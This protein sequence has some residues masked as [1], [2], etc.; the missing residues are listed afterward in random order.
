MQGLSNTLVSLV[1]VSKGLGN[2]VYSCLESVLLQAHRPTEVILIDNSGSPELRRQVGSKYPDVRVHVLG[3]DHSYCDSLN[4][5][6]AVSRGEFVLC[7]NDDVVLTA[8]FISEAL[9]GFT[10]DQ[11]IGMVSGKALRFD[12]Q[13][14]D[15]AGLSL[16]CFASARERGY[17]VRDKGQFET[18]GYIFG[19]CGAMA[20]YR[21]KMLDDIMIDSGF[22]DP[23][24]R[25]FYEDLDL[26]WRANNL[27]WKCFY[28]PKAIAYHLRGASVRDA[29]GIE[30]KH[31][32]L[33]LN[34]ELLAD[35]VKN[36]YL[37]IIK[38][39]S[40]WGFLLRLPCIFAY[41][42]I[43]WGHLLF[44]RPRVIGRVLSKTDLINRAFKKRSILKARKKALSR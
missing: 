13:T 33:Y 10:F 16:S 18:P 1:I 42:I 23:D 15:T 4:K 25:F 19:V 5:G 43:A 26:A 29:K 28:E 21:R 7:L 3:P 37:A 38:N 32:R 41:E 31:A 20:F 14:L 6:I 12:R 35:L 17:G 34:D 22:F 39:S 40:F 8:D 2:H 11:K 9:N 27:G 24:F 36:R 30:K 44:F